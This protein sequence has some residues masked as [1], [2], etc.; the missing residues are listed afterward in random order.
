MF[1]STAPGVLILDTGTDVVHA[2]HP[3]VAPGETSVH[4]EHHGGALPAAPVRAIRPRSAAEVAF[5]SLGPAAE[6]FITGAAG[7][8]HTR[9]GPKLAQLNT[10]TA[11]HGHAAMVTALERATAF[12]RWKASAV[13]SILAAGTGLPTPLPAGNALGHRPA[14]SHRAVAGRDAPTTKAVSS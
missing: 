6:A 11:A 5:C 10:L 3:I 14:H 4:G 1:S 13:R 12:G 2:E 9:L 7:A 8:G